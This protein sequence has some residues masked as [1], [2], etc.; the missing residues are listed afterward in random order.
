M[1]PVEQEPWWALFRRPLTWIA[2][3]GFAIVNAVVLSLGMPD[4]WGAVAS[5]AL[6]AA[7]VMVATRSKSVWLSIV[8]FLAVLATHAVLRLGGWPAF[9]AVIAIFAVMIWKPQFW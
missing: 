4:P 5:G 1:S 8:I 2:I 6:L 9:L 7:A 3:V